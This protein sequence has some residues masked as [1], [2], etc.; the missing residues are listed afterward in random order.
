ME[1]RINSQPPWPLTEPISTLRM[2]GIKLKAKSKVTVGAA[3]DVGR[4]R[5]NNED[6]F[7][8]F[9]ENGTPA[10]ERLYVVAD[11]M[12]G[13]VRGKDASST[14]VDVIG[15]AFTADHPT[16]VKARLK[17][18]FDE[19]NRAIFSMAFAG[20]E[21][22]TMGTTCTALSLS[23]S[24]AIIAHVGDSRAYRVRHD[25]VE[26]LTEDHTVAETLRKEGILSEEEALNH[27]RRHALTRAVGV[28]ENLQTDLLNVPPA[29]AGDHFVLCSDGLAAISIPD[30]QR[31]VLGQPPQQ[32]CE[33]LIQM[34]NEQG[35]FD[36]AT[37]IIVRIA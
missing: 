29:R 13:H 28:D 19:A 6:T 1:I 26:Q 31:V 15:R 33:T 22:L 17:N 34:A 24:S 5:S 2:F 7:G 36:N 8:L 23:D 30:L 25:A 10:E 32:A 11:G 27:P 3:S 4:V 9:P 16:S 35:G 14:A 20:G 37:V 18:G 12:G 21:Q